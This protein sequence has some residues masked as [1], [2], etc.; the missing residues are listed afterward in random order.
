MIMK[1]KLEKGEYALVGILGGQPDYISIYVANSDPTFAKVRVVQALNGKTLF[2]G[3]ASMGQLRA[4]CLE[5]ARA[6]NNLLSLQDITPHHKIT[7]D[8]FTPC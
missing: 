5:T 4:L 8:G 7:V 3:E 1:A 6:L 2:E